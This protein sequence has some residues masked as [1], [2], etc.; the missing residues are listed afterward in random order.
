[1]LAS[2]LLPLDRPGTASNAWGTSASIYTQNYTNNVGSVDREVGIVGPQNAGGGNAYVRFGW[3]EDFIDHFP[4]FWFEGNTTSGHY[5]SWGSLSGGSN[6]PLGVKNWVTFA[7]ISQG[8]GTWAVFANGTKLW[9]STNMGFSTGTT[10]VRSDR[11]QCDN[12]GD[13]HFR[14][15]EK[16]DSSL[17]WTHWSS[18]SCRDD[19][20]PS[21]HLNKVAADEWKVYTGDLSGGCGG[22]TSGP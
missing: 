18:S 8:D 1:M 10:I 6:P 9:T 11:D 15:I 13:S 12:F 4:I 22:T 19:T 16:A 7:V 14:S 20:D 21:W 3:S 17:K 2:N 5:S